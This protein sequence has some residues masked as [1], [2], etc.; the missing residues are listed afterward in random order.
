MGRVSGGPLRAQTIVKQSRRNE[1]SP[2]DASTD[3]TTAG[4]RGPGLAR[5]PQR[6]GDGVDET[7]LAGSERGIAV[8]IE[9]GARRAHGAEQVD[10]QGRAEDDSEAVARAWDPLESTCRHA[11]LSIL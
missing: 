11:S 1:G 8:V 10:P 6:A 2:P 4:D 7:T 5:K 9:G 3:P